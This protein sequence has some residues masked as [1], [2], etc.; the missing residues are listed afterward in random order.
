MSTLSKRLAEL[1]RKTGAIRGYLIAMQDLDDKDLFRGKAGKTYT[2]QE[3][4]ALAAEGWQ[5][6]R[7]V[8]E[9]KWR[10]DSEQEP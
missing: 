10:G 4:T 5:V 8:Y 9:E 3:L 2:D 6:I 1:E 7:V